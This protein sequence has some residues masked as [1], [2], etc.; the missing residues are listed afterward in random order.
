[1]T[2]AEESPPTRGGRPSQARRPVRTISA[3]SSSSRRPR[4]GRLPVRL[5][6]LGDPWPRGSHPQPLRHRFSAVRPGVIAIARS[7][8]CD[9][10]R[11]RVPDRRPDRPHPPHADLPGPV[12]R[13]GGRL[14][15][16]VRQLRSAGKQMGCPARRGHGRVRGLGGP[17]EPIG[18]LRNPPR[19][20]GPRT[21][22]LRTRFWGRP[23]SFGAHPGSSGSDGAA[24]PVRRDRVGRGSARGLAIAGLLLAGVCRRSQPVRSASTVVRARGTLRALCPRW[25]HSPA[26][27]W[28]ILEEL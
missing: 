11:H 26:G 3:M 21:S 5:R 25:D 17:L 27:V 28:S 4:D 7:A 10:S 24:V 20:S 1:M 22:A 8:V 18:A 13:P 12:H 15:A 2:R 9:R 14:G 23:Q 19:P 16:A 6:Q